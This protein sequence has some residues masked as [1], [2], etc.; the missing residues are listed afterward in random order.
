LLMKIWSY[1]MLLAD[2]RAPVGGS[3]ATYSHLRAGLR[4]CSSSRAASIEDLSRGV[5]I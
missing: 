1:L 4:I 2:A 5:N 3:N